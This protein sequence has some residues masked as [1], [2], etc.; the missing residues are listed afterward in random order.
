M[1]LGGGAKWAAGNG[2]QALFVNWKDN[3][4]AHSQTDGTDWHWGP[5]VESN[6]DD[7]RYTISSVLFQYDFDVEFAADIPD[8]LDGYDLVV[9]SAYYAI[10]PKHNQLMRDYISEGGGVVLLTGAPCLF[11]VYDKDLWTTT[12]L[13]SIQDWFG[14]SRYVNTRG[15]AVVTINNPFGTSMVNGTTLIEDVGPSAAAI[16]QINEAAQVVAKWESGEICAFTFEFGQGRVYY[17]AAYDILYAD[18][19]QAE[20]DVNPN[21]L[22]LKSNGRWIT[23]HI[24]LPEEC[25][26]QDIDLS[27]LMLNDTIPVDSEAPTNIGYFDDILVLMVKFDREEVSAFILNA[28]D[29][30]EKSIWV[31]LK[32]TGALNDGVSFEGVDTIR[33]LDPQW[34]VHMAW[35]YNAKRPTPQ[36]NPIFDLDDDGDLDIFD[37]V[38][39]CVHYGE[40]CAR[41]RYRRNLY[42]SQKQ[43]SARYSNRL[44]QL[45]EPIHYRFI[46]LLERFR[47]R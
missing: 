32:I 43:L 14:A 12:D 41:E 16:M 46:R 38:A 35:A 45:F 27:T 31:T 5:W 34:H 39:A 4:L 18:V 26:V 29:S 33:V 21:T 36:Y 47:I 40:S 25:D 37:I 20:V 30:S 15:D 24:E 44:L 9:L 7:W 6:M 23:A 11:P 1:L 42:F 17:Q 8:N 2:S 28:I 10:E 3:W 22:N 13:T 19:Y